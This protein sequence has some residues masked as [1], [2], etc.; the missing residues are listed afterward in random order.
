M[1][2][3]A[4]ESDGITR[5]RRALLFMPGDNRRMI[6]KASTLAVDGIIADLED[7][8][9]RDRKQMARETTVQAF[10]SLDFGYRERIIRLNPVR[11]EH[12]EL[13]LEWALRAQPDALMLPK[14]DGRAEIEEVVQRLGNAEAE[15]G[16]I[17]LIA[18]VESA[19][20]VL[21]LASLAAFGRPLTALAIGAED[22]AGDIG[23]TR[24]RSGREVLYARSALVIAASAY[25]LQAIDTVY[26]DLA[27]GE[28]L[29]NEATEARQMGYDGKLAIHPSQVGPIQRSFL[30]SQEEI[31]RAERLVGEFE[32]QQ[33]D[34]VGAFRF[35]GKM[36]D[37]PMVRS[38]RRLL[39]LARLAN[40]R[41][42]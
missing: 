24:T 32:Q 22:L 9:A 8:V 33:A 16:F 10:Q 21:E 41:D 35:E 40:Q 6:E 17:E 39:A 20:G 23:A 31:D 5:L 4:H 30:P 42:L 2:R 36:V 19:R 18:I 13:D 26:T 29:K 37:M 25:R 28:G 14:V 15:V 12:F 11:S 27:D 7:G 38:A 3:R 1:T 34:G